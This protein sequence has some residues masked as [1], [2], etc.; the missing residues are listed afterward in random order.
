MLDVVFEGLRPYHEV[1][2]T[3]GAGA[4]IEVPVEL[5]L[6]KVE[7]GVVVDGSGSR[8]DSGGS[9]VVTSFRDRG[10][11]RDPTASDPAPRTGS[12]VAP[13]ISPTSLACVAHSAL[14]LGGGLE[15]VFLIDGTSITRRAMASREL[16]GHRLQELRIQSVGASILSRV[17]SWT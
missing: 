15:S 1:G 2:I 3:I 4:I 17:L 13:G 8:M 11:R 14:R 12:K 6:S 16:I 7:Q 10:H 9:G 5:T